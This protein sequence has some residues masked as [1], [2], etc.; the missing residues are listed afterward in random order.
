MREG[1]GWGVDK[2]ACVGLRSFFC[3]SVFVLVA[4]CRLLTCAGNFSVRRQMKQ[5]DDNLRSQTTTG[6]TPPSLGGGWSIASELCA[7]AFMNV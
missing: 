6:A 4:F 1:G 3:V 5:Q 2:Y 7:L